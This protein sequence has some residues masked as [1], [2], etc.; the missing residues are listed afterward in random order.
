MGPAEPFGLHNVVETA[1]ARAL[2]LA[3]EGER[4]E[5]VARIATE[6]AAQRTARGSMAAIAPSARTG[7]K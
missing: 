5:L 2:V 4:W 3:A 7:R 1:L 6:L